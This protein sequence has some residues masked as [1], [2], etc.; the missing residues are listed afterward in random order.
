MIASFLTFGLLNTL[1]LAVAWTI[2]RGF[3][4]TEHLHDA[5]IRVAVIAFDAPF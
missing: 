3:F 1:A 5:C 2:Y 4:R